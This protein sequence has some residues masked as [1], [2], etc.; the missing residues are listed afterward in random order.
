MT[1]TPEL[2]PMPAD[3]LQTLW[4]AD[5]LE[6]SPMVLLDVH[7]RAIRFETIQRWHLITL[8]GV[9]LFG[10]VA[11]G[12]VMLKFQ[13]GLLSIGYSLVALSI[14]WILYYRHNRDP[15]NQQALAGATQDCFDFYKDVLKRR[16]RLAQ[17]AWAWSILPTLP[18]V[19]IIFYRVGQ[20][21]AERHPKA[22][23]TPSQAILVLQVLE[24]ALVV[25]L[26]VNFFIQQLRAR[27]LKRELQTLTGGSENK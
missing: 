22:L 13:D 10:F 3:E 14:L 4:Q 23:I 17:T 11:A 1:D 6:V 18:G 20:F 16:I 25:G 5:P 2:N 9:T 15:K 12:F 8:V 7:K 27:R 26:L 19:L 24:A 21:V